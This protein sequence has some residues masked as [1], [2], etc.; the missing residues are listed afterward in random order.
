M[1]FLRI[2]GEKVA[3]SPIMTD[4]NSVSFYR[5]WMCDPEIN[6]W[7]GH[8]GTVPSFE[9]EE[10]WAK[11]TSDSFKFS[12]LSLISPIGLEA[13]E[14]LLIGTAAIHKQPDPLTFSLGVCIGEVSYHNKGLGT[15]VMQLLL[16]HCFNELHAHRVIL[17]LNRANVKAFKCY[18]KAG[19]KVCGVAH[20]ARWVNG[21]YCDV[22]HMEIL[23]RDYFSKY[24]EPAKATP[25]Q[26]TE[27]D[28]DYLKI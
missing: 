19:F 22:I 16:S 12:I 11:D 3:L 20:D 5:K 28:L 14:P 1:D 18:K 4:Y 25:V 8:N 10:K 27:E 26:L 2:K 6:K 24:G 7:I 23:D 21:A 9:A 15:E 17:S 13:K